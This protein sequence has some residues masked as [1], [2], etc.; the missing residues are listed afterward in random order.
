MAKVERIVFLSLV[1]DL[2]AFTIP[3]PL[4]P[5]IIEWYTKRE[6]SDPTGFLSRTL[7]FVSATRGL[8]YKPTSN[9]Q[10]WDIVLLGG[11][12]GSVFSALQWF[13]SPHIGA[14]S[15]KYGRKRV[16]LVTMIGNILS[17][18]IWIQSTTFAS[19]LLSRVVGGISEGNVQLAIAILSDITTPAN[20]AKALA[21]VGIAFA[22][23]FCIG[24]PIGAYFASRPPPSTFTA[25][26]YELNVYATPAALTLIL[27][28]FETIFLVVALPE[29]RGKRAKPTPVEKRAT[30][31]GTAANGN[32]NGVGDKL[33]RAESVE[34][35]L[36]MLQV[37][38]RL[39]L[40]FLGVFSGVE[41]T[42]TFLTFDLFD[43]NNKQNGAL[44]GSIGI[45]SA[46]LQGGYV[47]RALPK[48]GEGKMAQRGI[49]SCAIG[50][51]LLAIMP[52]M[53]AEHGTVAVRLLQ[54]AA[55][56]M[57]FTSATVVNSLTAYASLQCDEAALD[58]DT[59]KPLAEHPQL[60]KGT[61]LGKFRSSGQLGRAIGPL[62]ACA[63]YWTFGPSLTYA[64]SA[65]A[66][67][68]LSASTKSIAARKALPTPS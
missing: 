31:N 59:G 54:G 44:I 48:I 58:A 40:L 4:F 53:V 16:L 34:Q 63:S 51:V 9:P 2:F 26:G 5:R 68:A 62:L 17:A 14:L 38:R 56:C 18:L 50:L 8:L 10:R 64:I 32:A 22:I 27:L 23:C 12:M 1:L 6:S 43:W 24:P 41:F 61:A 66:M 47:R 15:D 13:I 28:V 30:N 29:T 55:V 49:S 46:L 3:L 60:A 11:L 42:L 19:Y 52:H 20:R 45:I 65:F 36:T 33:S 67:F 39:H 37:L 25:S 35:R 7:Q 21:H 57:A